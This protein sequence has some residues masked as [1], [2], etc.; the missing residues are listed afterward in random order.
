[1][2]GLPVE[3]M[4]DLILVTGRTLV[5]SWAAAAF[6]DDT[7]MSAISLASKTLSDGVSS[8]AWSNIQGPVVHHNSRSDPQNPP[9]IA[10]QCVF[11]RGFRA[12]R[13]FLWVRLRAA[14]E[15][16]PDDP[17]N[18]SYDEIQVQVTQVPGASKCHNPLAGILDYIPE[19]CREEYI[20]KDT[21]SIV[22]DNDLKLTEDSE[23][24]DAVNKFLC[25][26]GSLRSLGMVF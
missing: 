17:D 2:K 13:V 16:R 3:R 25:N 26:K 8:F 20:A 18:R 19:N 11:I 12:K 21:T 24:V 5:T 15:P 7:M 14:A 4:E 22:H 6:V 1:M 10:D 23:T 9:K